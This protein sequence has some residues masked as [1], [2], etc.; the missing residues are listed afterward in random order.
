[1][2]LNRLLVLLLL[3]V[4]LLPSAALADGSD[5]ARFAGKDW[6]TVVSEFM[7]ERRV[8]PD[9]VGI[10]YYNTVTGE[11]HAINGDR[12]R[13]A[14]SV[15]KLPLNMYYAD[16][17]TRGEM[18]MDDMIYGRTYADM[19]RLSLEN[20][21]NDVSEVLRS[22]FG[23]R[24]DY[25]KAIAYLLSDDPDALCEDKTYVMAGYTNN[26]TPNLLLHALKLLYAEPDRFP[27]VLEHMGNAQQEE[28]FCMTERRF[29][30]AHKY[31]CF[32]ENGTYTV[33]DC[34]VIYTDDPILLVLL[35]DH[36]NAA[37]TFMADFTT[38][39][40]DYAQYTRSVRLADEAEADAR[41][42]EAERLAAEARAKAEAEAAAKRAAE[43]EA[44]ALAKAEAEAAALARLERSAATEA[45]IRKITIPLP[46]T[47]GETGWRLLS[48]AGLAA[49][50]AL[51][52][53]PIFGRKPKPAAAAAA[54]AEPASPSENAE[55]A[56]ES[57]SAE[58]EGTEEAG[59]GV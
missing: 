37:I 47:P 4:L 33:N 31:G 53:A 52:C 32:L 38:L 23:T 50:L 42:A 16:Q 2:K 28:Y 22:R 27:V 54:P 20:S 39:M 58:A 15:Y 43:A 59:A 21:S 6:D 34:G 3:A 40:C 5:D 49:G 10:A 51:I 57:A 17:V 29:K 18:S 13:F 1:M 56:S 9:T 19:Q 24:E 8:N 36:A 35:T 55:P 12:Y 45:A 25:F 48:A 41:L 11:E 46:W 26:F 30:I 14:A 44:E 7:A